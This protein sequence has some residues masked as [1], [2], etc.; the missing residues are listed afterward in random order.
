MANQHISDRPVYSQGSWFHT[1][2]ICTGIRSCR[3]GRVCSDSSC[4]VGTSTFTRRLLGSGNSTAEQSRSRGGRPAVGGTVEED[5]RQPP[6]R[7]CAAR[8]TMSTTSTRRLRRQQLCHSRTIA[9]MAFH[10][11][12]HQEGLG[13]MKGA[14]PPPTPPRSLPNPRPPHP[15]V[16]PTPK[17]F[18]LLD[19]KQFPS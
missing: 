16:C 1:S 19:P 9:L 7:P 5:R 15:E 8:V 4:P 18:W 6:P 3:K 11:K 13:R 12:D 10:R 2:N 17:I 14:Q